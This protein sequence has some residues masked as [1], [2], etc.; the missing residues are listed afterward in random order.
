MISKW[1]SSEKRIDLEWDGLLVCTIISFIEISKRLTKLI[2][3]KSTPDFELVSDLGLSSLT[4]QR[5]YWNYVV[6]I[7]NQW[8]F[9]LRQI[10]L[11]WT[12]RTNRPTKPNSCDFEFADGFSL[13]V[14]GCEYDASII[15]ANSKP[16]CIYSSLSK[17]WKTTI[18]HF[19]AKIAD[20]T[21]DDVFACRGTQIVYS[22]LQIL[23]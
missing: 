3:R 13:F 15:P 7:T 1:L 11:L 18:W 21:F 16:L 14:F 20:K 10:I 4:W 9:V 5:E 12:G 23:S 8:I 19:P 17:R 2:S 6:H 22:F